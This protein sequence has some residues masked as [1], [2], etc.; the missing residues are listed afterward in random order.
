MNRKS[1][2]LFVCVSAQCRSCCWCCCCCCVANPFGFV[3]HI[4]FGHI[5]IQL[6]CNSHGHTNNH[7]KIDG[8]FAPIPSKMTAFLL[9]RLSS[10]F[11]ILFYSATLNLHRATPQLMP[12]TSQIICIQK[13]VCSAGGCELSLLA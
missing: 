8:R 11:L 9:L 1:V 10:F 13:G 12:T 7:Y 2:R 4:N 5:A 6:P 3:F